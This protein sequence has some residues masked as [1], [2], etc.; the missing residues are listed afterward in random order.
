MAADQDPKSVASDSDESEVVDKERL[1]LLLL[2][3]VVGMLA[4]TVL[5]FWAAGPVAGLIVMAALVVTVLT[6]VFRRDRRGNVEVRE[7]TGGRYRVLVVAH[8]GLGGERLMEL[9]DMRQPPG[10]FEIHVV[11]PA[12][13]SSGKRMASDV[14][15]GIESAQGDLDR[16]LG[17]LQAERRSVAGSVGD[18]DPRLA[19]EDAL[20]Q[21]AA[22]EIVVVNPPDSEMSRL[23]RS[24]TERAFANVPLPVRE[25]QS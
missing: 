12:L 9:L 14:D 18:S 16:L 15:E 24:S 7:S 6:L 25:V 3:G 11:V 4:V 10:G 2:A 21:F 1:G 23:E 19:L 8:E 22:D 5:A 13:T 17:E 20:R